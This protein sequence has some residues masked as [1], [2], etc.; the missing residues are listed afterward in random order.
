MAIGNSRIAA[1]TYALALGLCECS[2]AQE[3]DS[4]SNGQPRD[5]LPEI[6]VEAPPLSEGSAINVPTAVEPAPSL[7]EAI[8]ESVFDFSGSPLNEFDASTRS[9]SGAPVNVFNTPDAVTILGRDRLE[10]RQAASTPELLE[11]GLPGVFIQRTNQGG[12]SLLLRG[13]NGNQNLILV[14]GIPINDSGWRFGNVQYLNVMDPGLIDRVEIL[15]GPHS[16]MYGNGATG[17]VLNLVTKRRTDYASRLGADGGVIMNYGTAVDDIYTRGEF[18]GNYGR[19]GIFGGVSYLGVGSVYAGQDITFDNTDYDQVAADGRMDYLIGDGWVFTYAY[20]HFAQQS[21]PRTDRFPDRPT[22]I[23]PQQRNFMY[24]RLANYEI[25]SPFIHGIETT[26]SLQ[27]R[28]EGNRETDLRRDPPRI[29]NDFVDI[30]YWTAETRGFTCLGDYNTVSYGFFYGS[31]SVDAIRWRGN[32]EDGLE[33]NTPILPNDGTYRQF[34]VYAMD[35]AQLADWLWLDAGVRYAHVNAQGTNGDDIHFDR[36]YD[37]VLSEYGAVVALT[38]TLHVTGRIAEGFRAPNLD[39]LGSSDVPSSTGQD[40]GSTTL[41]AER[42]WSYE[43]G[44]K[45]LSENVQGGVTLYQGNYNGLIARDVLPDDT[46]VRENMHGV[47]RGAELDGLVYLTENWAMYGT[48]TYLF[49]QNTFLD[50]PLRVPPA[51]YVAGSRWAIPRYNAFIEAFGEFAGSQTRLGRIDRNDS[52]VPD[53]GEAAWQTA[54]VRGG[55]NLQE[56]G[57]LTLGLYN[58]FDQN[59]RV[60]GSGVDAPGIDFRVGYILSF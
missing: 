18:S 31:D 1:W 5:Q 35:H 38:R 50:E 7:A 13:R 28:K 15:R 37:L 57:E 2:E 9:I 56:W 23:D 19:L 52:R 26:F 34:G 24:W 59:Y 10:Q 11:G 30:K 17:G 12:G 29:T 51:I 43:V 8:A 45:H 21:V 58:I 25:D 60:L 55:V 33:P 49:G 39:D 41:G 32:Q 4:R 47:I 42:V 3:T 53:G 54:N 14:D 44:L 36:N 48:Y 22:Y 27:Q 20:Q 46:N 16:V 6:I 40:F